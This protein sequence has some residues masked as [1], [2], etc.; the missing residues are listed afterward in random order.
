MTPI[1]TTEAPPPL[2]MVAGEQDEPRVRRA[3]PMRILFLVSAHNSLSQ[4]VMVAL[5][6]AGHEVSVAVVDGAGPMEAAVAEHD[7]ELIVCPF[8][9]RMIPAS[10]WSRHRCLIVHP[11]PVGDRGPSSLDWAIQLGS[12]HWGVT[13]LEANGEPDAGRVLATR[14]FPMRAAPK[15]S[16]YRHEVRGAAVAAVLE[17]IARIGEAEEPAAPPPPRVRGRARPLMTQAVRTIDWTRH[18][19]DVIVGKVRAG[20][21]AP[22]VLDEVM[23]TEFHLFG[24]HREAELDGAAG[25]IIAQRD[26]AICRA[27]IDGAVW[28]TH[29]TRR[30]TASQ[31]FFKLPATR[32]LALAGHTLEVPE[33]P[34]APTAA[35]GPDRTFREITYTE[36]GSVGYLRFDFHNGAMSTEQCDRLRAAYCEARARRNT[37]VIVLLGGTDYFSNGI[38]LNVIEAADNPAA[39]SLRNL[40][41]M[42]ELVCEIVTTS[43]KLV[44]AAIG[45][46]VAAGG[47]PL[48]LAADHVVAHWDVVFNP[49]YQHMGGLY[50][51]EYW[52]Y[53]LPR[54]IGELAAA[55]I[56]SAPFR[57]VGA[58]A[59]ARMGLIDATLGGSQRGFETQTRRL[60]TW[61]ADTPGLTRR[62]ERKRALR[63]CDEATKP[64][65]AYREEE[66]ARSCECFFGSDRSYHE[67]RRRFVYKTP[68]GQ[69]A[70]CRARPPIATGDPKRYYE[71]HVLAWYALGRVSDA[72]AAR[73]AMTHRTH[74]HGA[75]I[76]PQDA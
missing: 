65:Q 3:D 13:V 57:P 64:L 8:L 36:R 66:M 19:A 38:H 20:D 55:R 61:L 30:D 10:I 50:G 72:H 47:V 43:S 21:S 74:R 39:E 75:G 26:G 28:I 32:A 76:P 62:L 23:G 17:A 48:A 29:L 16:L 45:G 37:K 73:E 15:C 11:G 49:Y 9:K 63:L 68:P 52:T 4:R 35:L 60:A 14:E 58:D 59:A 41:A 22:G 24:A 6:D 34:V 2:R 42:N 33:R 25:E 51:S 18:R 12:R 53:L 1:D 56:T 71:Q 27:T 7:P 5:R 31:R 44:I 69:L 67:A 46:D 40:T 70:P 54:R